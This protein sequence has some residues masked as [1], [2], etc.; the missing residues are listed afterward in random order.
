MRIDTERLLLRPHAIED[1]DALGAMIRDPEVM[2]HITSTVPSD[3]DVWNR[4]LR[5]IG[6]WTAF[7]F[8]IFAVIERETGRNIGSVGFADFRRGLGDAFSASPEGAWL[9]AK[10]AHGRGIATEATQAMHAWFDA[11]PFGGRSVCI[12]NPDNAPSRRLARRLGY[13]ETG[14]T[15]YHDEAILTF[16]RLR[17]G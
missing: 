10:E 7:G 15:R 12:I 6:H 8:G 3:E 9:F 1:F 16:E 11:Q 17:P 14:V 5:Y 4:L 2:R 13:V